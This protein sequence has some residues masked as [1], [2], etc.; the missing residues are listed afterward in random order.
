MLIQSS[1]A[2]KTPAVMFVY[3]QSGNGYLD[4]TGKTVFATKYPTGGEFRSAVVFGG[5]FN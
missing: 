4:P 3:I 2:K 5:K 1:A